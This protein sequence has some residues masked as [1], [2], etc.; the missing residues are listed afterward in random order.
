MVNKGPLINYLRFLSRRFCRVSQLPGIGLNAAID[1]LVWPA[2]LWVEGVSFGQQIRLHGRPWFYRHPEAEITI[3]H[4]VH[5]VS[6]PRGSHMYLTRPCTIHALGPG[7]R[8]RIGDETHMGGA[9]ILAELS[10]EIGSY[11]RIA[12]GA[13]IVD[14]DFQSLNPNHRAR[15]LR[16]DVLRRPV[17]IGDAVLVGARAIVLK[18]VTIGDG[19]IIGAGAVVTQNVKPGEIVMGNPARCIATIPYLGAKEST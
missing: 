10:I 9:T 19:A 14:T 2:L 18:G 13:M 15:S 3:G 6:R 5:L 12:P 7:A 17:K 11:V 8:I 1:R 4:N 16:H